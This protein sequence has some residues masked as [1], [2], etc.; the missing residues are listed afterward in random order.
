VE[1]YVFSPDLPTVARF[2]N[3]FIRNQSRRT[4]HDDLQAVLSTKGKR[5]SSSKFEELQTITAEKE[6]V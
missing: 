4:E 5:K 6:A 3:S 2:I 1:N